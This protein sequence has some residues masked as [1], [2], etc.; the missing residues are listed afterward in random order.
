VIVLLAVYLLGAV[1]FAKR[2]DNV[3][4]AMGRLIHSEVALTFGNSSG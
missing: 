4:S 3:G 2:S 1:A